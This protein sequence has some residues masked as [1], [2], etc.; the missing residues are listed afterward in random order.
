MLDQQ[1]VAQRPNQKW[2]ADITYVQTR[3]GWLYLAGVLDLYSRRI[4]G[5]AMDKTMGQELVSRALEMALVGRKPDDGLVHH[6]DRGSQYAA[7]AYQQRLRDCGVSIS[8]SRRANCYDNSPIESFWSTLKIECASDVFS[9]RA[10]ARQQIFEYIEVWY[11][12]A[13]RHSALGYQNPAAF[14]RLHPRALQLSTKLA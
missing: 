1:F 5:W 7:R 9:S 14:E 10:S 12:R 8:M 4:V 13:R 2:L 6:S 11:N 3:E